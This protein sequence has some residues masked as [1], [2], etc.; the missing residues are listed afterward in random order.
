MLL[1]RQIDFHTLRLVIKSSMGDS[2]VDKISV[3]I[4]VLGSMGCF[5]PNFNINVSGSVSL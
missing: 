4:S 3:F 5:K 1:I 2:N